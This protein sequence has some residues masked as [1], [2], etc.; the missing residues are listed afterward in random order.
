[1]LAITIQSVCI[2]LTK[3]LQ[4]PFDSLKPEAW[5]RCLTKWGLDTYKRKLEELTLEKEK[6]A[7]KL[8]GSSTVRDKSVNDPA[9]I[10][11]LSQEAKPLYLLGTIDQKRTIIRSVFEHIEVGRTD[12]YLSFNYTFSLL[13]KAVELTNSSKINKLPDISGNIFEPVR[14]GSFQSVNQSKTPS[15]ST[16]RPAWLPGKDS[17]LRSPHPE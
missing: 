15:L 2:L 10:F 8:K 4:L 14:M 1:L 3:C 11:S 17:N 5:R 13:A 6:I 12:M 9:E 16:E 7:L